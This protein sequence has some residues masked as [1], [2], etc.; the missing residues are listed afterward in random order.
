MV[1]SAAGQ[2]ELSAILRMATVVALCAVLA[3]A[4]FLLVQCAL[5]RRVKNMK[6]D[7]RVPTK[8]VDAWSESAKRMD[9]SS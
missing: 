8:L 5:R 7:T 3:A 1:E 2:F 4:V 6:A 9:G